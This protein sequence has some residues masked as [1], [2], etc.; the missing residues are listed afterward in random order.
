MKR[1][2]QILSLGVTSAIALSAF[3]AKAGDVDASKAVVTAPLVDP[4]A[5]T[6]RPISNPTLFDLAIPQTQIHPLFIHN[7]MP[8]TVDTI[9]GKVPVGGDFQ[10]YAMQVEIALNDRLS[11]NAVKD[12]YIDFNPDST[13]TTSDGWANIEAGLKYAW[14]LQPEQGLASNFQLQYEIPTGNADVWQGEGDGILT[15]SMSVLK[16][17]GKFQVADQFGFRLPIDDSESSVFYN[18]V[19]VSYKLTDWLFPL[20]EVNVFH[21]MDAGDGSARFPSQVGGLVPAIAKF[22][23]GDLVNLGASNTVSNFVSLALGARVRIPDSP[24]DLGFAWEFPLTDQDNGL[25]E[26]RFTV[27][28]VIRF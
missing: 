16:L 15:P 10:V 26:D 6:I 5:D 20:A 12:G 1:Y 17:L 22:E 28:M 19:H 9:L 18:S 21:V 14:L 11:I 27:D 13:L 7:R 2:Q 25:M 24:I 3:A 23:G 4:W 8:D